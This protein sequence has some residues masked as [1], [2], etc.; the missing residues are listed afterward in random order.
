M[1]NMKKHSRA[2]VVLITFRKEGNRIIINYSDN[3]TGMLAV[4]EI[5]RGGLWNAENRME[6]VS[7]SFTFNSRREKG[8]KGILEFPV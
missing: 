8:F 1:V 6:A 7:G 2:S 4:K 5:N 3:G